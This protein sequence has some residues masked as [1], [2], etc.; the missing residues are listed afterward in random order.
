MGDTGGTGACRGT[1]ATKQIHNAYAQ[2][3]KY[4]DKYP[5]LEQHLDDLLANNPKG[6]QIIMKFKRMLGA[7]KGGNFNTPELQAVKKELR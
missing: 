7:A 3:K 6:S 5:T 4:L 2:Q 1:T